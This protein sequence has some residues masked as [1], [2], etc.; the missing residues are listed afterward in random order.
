MELQITA[1][2]AFVEIGLV[3]LFKPFRRGGLYGV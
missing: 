3:S 1:T 2:V